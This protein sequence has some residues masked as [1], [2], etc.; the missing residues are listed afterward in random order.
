[1]KALLPLAFAAALLASGCK[2]EESHA[3][4]AEGDLPTQQELDAKAAEA[5]DDSNA[6]QELQELQDEIEKD[7]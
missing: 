3:A 7:G 2:K 6:D 1:M 4:P 5:I